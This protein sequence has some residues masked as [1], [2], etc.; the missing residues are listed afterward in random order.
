MK[1]VIMYHRQGVSDVSSVA[2]LQYGTVPVV[3]S[4]GGLVDTVKEGVTGFHIGAL[5]ADKLT[6]E[7]ADAVAATMSR[8]SQVFSTPLYKEMVMNSISQD[9]SWAKPARKWEGILE[10]M[11]SGV[12]SAKKASVKVP[13]ENPIPGDK[14]PS[15]ILAA[16]PRPAEGAPKPAIRTLGLVSKTAAPAGASSPSTSGAAKPAA[17]AAGKPASTPSVATS[18]SPSNTASPVAPTPSIVAA[19]VTTPSEP[20]KVTVSSSA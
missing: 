6:P 11:V 14:P 12:S 4:T 16:S 1:F 19:P 15:P 17:G 9:L 5:D 10:E 20:K 7:D 13:V 8:A 2:L 18:A 3:A